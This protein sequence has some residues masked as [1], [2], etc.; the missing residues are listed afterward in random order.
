MHKIKECVEKE[1]DKIYQNGITVQNLEILDKLVD[2]HKDIANEEYWDVVK[3]GMEM[4]DEYMERGRNRY[5]R[6]GQESYNRRGGTN[7]RGRYGNYSERG[8]EGRNRL[9]DMMDGWDE[10]KD[11]MDEYRARGTYGAKEKGIESLEYMLDAFVKWFEDLAKE[12]ETQEEIEII[13]K[14]ANKIRNV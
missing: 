1:I 12:A 3:E 8:T 6:S 14:Y 11:G 2:I 10:Y 7:G 13:K 9:Y 4:G 5:G